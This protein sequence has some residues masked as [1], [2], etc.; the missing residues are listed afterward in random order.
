[1][2]GPI[3]L[4]ST[5]VVGYRRQ[6]YISPAAEKIISSL[7]PR[8]VDVVLVVGPI[9][10]GKSHLA[11]LL[12]KKKSGFPLG[13]EMESKTKDFWFWIGP[14]PFQSDRYLMVVDTEGLDDYSD[15]EHE[16]KDMKHLVLATL[17]S[18]HLVFNLQG[19]P[20]SGLVNNLRLMGDLAE[21][22]RVQKDGSDDGSDLGEHFPE[23]WVAV[24]DVRLKTPK[25][26]GRR[27]TPDE[28][29]EMLLEHKGGHT[30]AIRSHNET[31]SAVKTFFQK[32]HLRL[33]PEPSGKLDELGNL[34][35][36]SD[37]DL[38]RNYKDAVGSFTREIWN[39][40]QVKRVNGD[41]IKPTGFLRILQ[42]YVDAINDPNG[43]PSILGAYEAMT[44]GECRRAS[45]EQ[46][47]KFQETVETTV[48]PFM[49]T[50]E[51][52]CDRKIKAA[53]ETAVTKLSAAV[54]H[55]DKDGAWKRGLQ[56]KLERQRRALLEDNDT[57]SK[58]L[59]DR[60]LKKADQTVQQKEEDGLYNRVGGFAAY[61]GDMNAVYK[62]YEKNA[63]GKGPAVDKVLKTFRDTEAKRRNRIKDM[64]RTRE[65]EAERKK[66]EAEEDAARAR[67]QARHEVEGV[68]WHESAAKVVD[69]VGQVADTADH[70]ME[71]KG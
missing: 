49:P 39:S 19:N 40:G 22:I 27:L 42:Y 67:R 18:S 7:Q 63:S 54:G 35:R 6:I 34:D 32:R 46:M 65:E 45:E 70:M 44:E 37:S 57:K 31:T 52:I 24:Q 4:T 2:D 5:R 26:N 71:N 58:D 21:R 33:I 30:K 20:D 56:E 66:R 12:C 14:H 15:E 10:K 38:K 9:R 1:M 8:P 29:L 50:D 28:F 48:K 23:L 51:E 55:W 13:D 25:R 43:M 41:D 53:V 60:I 47:K 17:I 64:V 69:T 36:V 68:K 59:C 3:K 11:N 16:D 62:D 61:V